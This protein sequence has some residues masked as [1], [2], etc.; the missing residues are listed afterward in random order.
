MAKVQNFVRNGMLP[1][2]LPPNFTSET[3]ARALTSTLPPFA[4]DKTWVSTALHSLARPSG[5][6]RVLSIPNPIGHYRIS[7]EV[8]SHWDQIRKH[9]LRSKWSRSLPTLKPR[10]QRAAGPKLTGE[11][12]IYEKTGC[13][14]TA[15]YLL[16]TDIVEFYRS[17]YTHSIPWALEG[18]DHVKSVMPNTTTLWSNGLDVATRQGQSGQTNGI[19]CGPDTSFILG[20]ILLSAVDVELQH[21]LHFVAG[22]RYYD[23]Y[24]LAVSTWG[25]AELALNYLQDELAKFGLQLNSTKTKIIELPLVAE[26]AIS[27]VKAFPGSWRD[28]HSQDELL[29]FYRRVF[30]HRQA[31]PTSQV[32]TFAL[33]RMSER[34]W[35]RRDWTLAQDLMSQAVISDTGAMHQYVRALVKLRLRWNVVPDPERLSKCLSQIVIQHAPRGHGNEVAWALWACMAFDIKLTKE[36]ATVISEMDDDVVALSAL[37]LDSRGGFRPRSTRVAGHSG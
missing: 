11:E 37:E 32:V 27:W 17:V 22:Y 13:R 21:K 36:C 15:R 14:A 6:R 5:I 25:E 20:E 7:F 35:S 30:E 24:E 9:L 16:R 33:S 23:D 34:P 26:G 2:E 10:N 28:D 12:T 3:F 18:K 1:K 4:T 8:A 19:P 29:E 31:D